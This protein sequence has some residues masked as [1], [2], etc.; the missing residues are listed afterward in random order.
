MCGRMAAAASY[1]TPSPPHPCHLICTTAGPYVWQSPCFCQGLAGLDIPAL[2][3][4]PCPLFSVLHSVPSSQC[5]PF[6]VLQKLVRSPHPVPNGMVS[7]NMHATMKHPSVTQHSMS[8]AL[9]PVLPHSQHATAQEAHWAGT[10]PSPRHPSQ[11]VSYS[12]L[13]PADTLLWGLTLFLTLL[14]LPPQS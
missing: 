14:P 1:A 2:P 7:L 10:L 3:C 5:P 6:S 9:L 13:H 8:Q 12:A 4:S 11:L